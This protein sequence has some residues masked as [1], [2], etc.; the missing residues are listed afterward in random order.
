MATEG[1]G[2]ADRDPGPPGAWR[3]AG[4]WKRQR[5]LL[6]LRRKPAVI[7]V[8]DRTAWLSWSWRH[9]EVRLATHP[10]RIASVVVP[11]HCGRLHVLVVDTGVKAI[12][13]YTSK[14]VYVPRSR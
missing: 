11:A 8:L 1:L 2:L 10:E 7:E 3:Q 12:V 14:G 9:A 13:A 6:G 5:V 4:P